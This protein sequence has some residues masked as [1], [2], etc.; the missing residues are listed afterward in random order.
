MVALGARAA[1]VEQESVPL[2]TVQRLSV[3]EPVVF[4]G[5]KS[6]MTTPAGAVDRPLF[7]RVIVYVVDVPAVTVGTPSSLVICR[8]AEV[9]TVSVSVERLFA[10]FPSDTGLEKIEAVFESTAPG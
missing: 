1:V 5:N 3:V 2:E 6:W 10:E 9:L 4:A 7:L 8:S